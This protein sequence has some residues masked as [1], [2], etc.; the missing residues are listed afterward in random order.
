MLTHDPHIKCGAATI[1][2]VDPKPSNSLLISK[3]KILGVCGI[4]KIPLI[5]LVYFNS[6]N[7]GIA[8]YL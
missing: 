1:T 3:Y 7:L 4:P 6:D 8:K 2:I 5:C